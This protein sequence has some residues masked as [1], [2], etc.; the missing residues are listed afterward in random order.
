MDLRLGQQNDLVGELADGVMSFPRPD[1]EACLEPSGSIFEQGL[2]FAWCCVT[3][4]RGGGVEPEA[5]FERAL[6]SESS[7]NTV[8]D[9]VLAVGAKLAALS[10]ERGEHGVACFEAKSEEPARELLAFELAA[11]VA[12]DAKEVAAV[13]TFGQCLGVAFS[14]EDSDA[15]DDGRERVAR[16][17]DAKVTFVIEQAKA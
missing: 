14:L 3:K 1:S 16:D 10:H 5:A 4:Q 2:M 12:D 6:D 7:V 15:V 11:E 8:V 9:G 17:G 13:N